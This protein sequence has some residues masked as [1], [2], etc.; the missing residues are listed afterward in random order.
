MRR[1]HTIWALGV[2]GAGLLAVPLL[3]QS[4]ASGG[5]ERYDMRAGTTSGMGA[6]GA[7]GR[8]GMG[9]MGAMFGEGGNAVQHELYLR[10]GSGQ[11]A[12]PGAPRAEHFMPPNARLGKSVLLVSPRE[13][14]GSVDELPQR[15][16]GRMPIY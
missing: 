8:G 7:G 10:I 16:K 12:Q 2:A 9:A 6:M 4:A 15:P 1:M 3:G 5:P 14:R 11:A 13:E